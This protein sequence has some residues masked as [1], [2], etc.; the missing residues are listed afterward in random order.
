MKT[1]IALLFVL[2]GV[3]S[4]ALAQMS[5][6]GFPITHES[7]NMKSLALG[8][9]T[10]S[11]S[12]KYGDENIN[13]AGIGMEGN[14][15]IRPNWN[16]YLHP[17]RLQLQNRGMSTNYS[18][19]NS[20]IA[21]SVHRVET[22]ESIT[23]V[24]TYYSANFNYNTR[25]LYVIGTYAYNFQNGLR[26]GSSLNYMFSSQT[27]G[28]AISAQWREAVDTWSIDLG[29]QYQFSKI[30][31]N[32]GSLKPTLGVALTDIGN[33]VSYTV[34]DY[35]NPL[36]MT[37]RAGVGI[38]FMAHKKTF[39]QHL[40]QFS[41]LQNVSKVMVRNK[42]KSSENG[43]YYEAM[44]PLQALIQSWDDFDNYNGQKFETFKLIEQ[45]WWHSGVEMKLLETF[46]LRWGYQ[47]AGKAEDDLSY[48][49]LGLGLDLFYV[50][51]DY[52]FIDNKEKGNYLEGHHWQLTGR[53]PLDGNKPDT[54]LHELFK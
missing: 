46:A 54:I 6:T 27:T 21:F 26:L 4:L 29:A 33:P 17:L 39:G 7:F 38:K 3:N 48:Y 24:G 41:I 9:A 50:N 30:N 35:N 43:V 10:V 34:S 8:Q 53:I 44:N 1:S 25:D 49:S 13:P 37:L 36:P 2:F 22:G 5:I 20:A 12:G 47:K 31:L 40:A 28:S 51:I 52:T 42:L 32:S 11:L 15:Q 45:I 14:L 23:S 18:S 19:G 16:T